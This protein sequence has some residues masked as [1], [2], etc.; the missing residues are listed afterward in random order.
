MS[1][2]EHNMQNAKAVFVMVKTKWGSKTK[3]KKAPRPSL[4]RFTL[5]VVINRNNDT[6]DEYE[7][8][9][10]S[11][12]IDFNDKRPEVVIAK[13]I[14]K[15][16]HLPSSS[17]LPPG[18]TVGSFDVA[19]STEKFLPKLKNFRS[20]QLCNWLK[21]PVITGKCYKLSRRGSWKHG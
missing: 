14:D 15:N 5:T 7:E 16:P 18:E 3:K 9:H 4:L 12:L 1:I 8:M 13:V 6:H 17:S 10:V 20:Y 11:D 2:R 21:T 19:Q